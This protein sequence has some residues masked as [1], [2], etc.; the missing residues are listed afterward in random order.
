MK[1]LFGITELGF[2][3]I[4]KTCK[5]L[6]SKNIST[7]LYYEKINLSKINK[8]IL[9][10]EKK[11][12]LPIFYYK[13][14]RDQKNLNV[15]YKYLH[16]L[17]SKILKNR[18]IWYCISQDRNLGRGYIK[19]ILG[20]SSYYTK[21]KQEVI[22]ETI[23]HAKNI[24]KILKKYK[25]DVFFWPTC[26]SNKD[27]YLFYSF[28]KFYKIKFITATTSRFQNYFYFANDLL[29]SKKTLKK[30]Y[31]QNLKNPKYDK[32]VEKLYTEV[33]QTG[34]ISSDSILVEQ[35]LNYLD[36]NILKKISDFTLFLVKHILMWILYSL[37]IKMKTI[38]NTSSYPLFPPIYENFKKITSVL[39]LSKIKTVTN[40]NQNFIYFPLHKIP[41][42]STQ[43]KG[44]KYMDQLYL[45]ESLS[46]NLPINYKLF[47]KEHP[48]MLISHSRDKGFYEIINKFPNVE[49][50]DFKLR[51]KEIIKKTKLVVILDSTSGIEALLEGKPLLTMVP[52]VY[53]FLNLSVENKNIENLN[54]D[55][56]KAISLNDRISKSTRKDKI[57]S[58]LKSV[59]VNSHKMSDVDTFYYTA[60]KIT[61]KGFDMVAKDYSNAIIKELITK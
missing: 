4:Y 35:N 47:V 57:K 43:T 21:K 54:S 59:L 1:I 23:N 25:P 30:N 8:E 33:S 58:L 27:A 52:F 11:N 48:S 19:D 36:S 46:K 14:K 41:E 31:L 15:D 34:K 29:Y 55:I 10:K 61:E 5:I 9:K 3:Y 56:K 18:S 51:P 28:C 60:N 45:I 39:Y 32:K 7:A 13:N 17:D 37:N 38:V 49:I 2:P 16:Y 22:I 12:A 26:L 20:Y 24:E 6:K 44:N 50:I 42:F 53:D 40:L